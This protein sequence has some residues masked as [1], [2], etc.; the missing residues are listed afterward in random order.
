[1]RQFLEESLVP[2]QESCWDWWQSRA[3]IYP[4][5][6]DVVRERLCL[7]ASSAPCDRLYSRSGA[8]LMD[9][10]SRLDQTE[11]RQLVFLNANMIVS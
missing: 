1:V 11:V 9:R 10:R 7:V 5:L 2:R 8:V 4:R 3:A 6:L